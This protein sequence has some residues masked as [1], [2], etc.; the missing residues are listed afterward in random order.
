[1]PRKFS[2]EYV[3]CFFYRLRVA[4]FEKQMSSDF[5]HNSDGMLVDVVRDFAMKA[6]AQAQQEQEQKDKTRLPES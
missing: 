5:D 2:D 1:M 6:Q 3:E 4:K